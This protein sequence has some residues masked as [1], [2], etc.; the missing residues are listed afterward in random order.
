MLQCSLHSMTQVRVLTVV[1]LACAMASC[2]Q[3]TVDA[4]EADGRPNILL[5]D[6]Q[7]RV[8]GSLMRMRLLPCVPRRGPQ[9]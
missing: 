5:I 4:A 3:P 8:C 6:L 9:C 1:T 2:C 7:N